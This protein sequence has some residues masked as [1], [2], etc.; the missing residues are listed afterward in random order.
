[1]RKTIAIIIAVMLFLGISEPIHA[2]SKAELD[3]AINRSAA[4]ILE[5]VR[6]PQVSSVGGEW[7]VLGLAR[8]G[9]D[10]PEAYFENYIRNVERYLRENNGVLHDRR[11]T[12]YSR[13]ILALTAAGYDPRN[14]AGFDLTLPLGDFDRVV[15]QGINGPIWALLALDSFNYPIPEN[16][17]AV[18]QATREL[19][20]ADILRRQTP[21]GGWNL[22]AGRNGV[23]SEN[24][25]GD[26]GLTGMALQALAKYQH[27][28]EV[29][30]ATERALGF[31]SRVQ[32]SDGGFSGDFAGGSYD[33]ESAVQVIVALSE[34][35]IAADDSRFV[36][37]GNT[38]LDNILRSQNADGSFNRLGE[39]NVRGSFNLMSTEQSFYGL[40]AVQRLAEG[41]NSLYRMTDTVQRRGLQQE[42]ASGLPNRH[43]DVRAVQVT[44]PGRTFADIQGHLNEAAI[45]RLVE[46][47][48]I[49]GMSENSFAP[50]DTMTRAEFAT[51]VTRSLGLPQVEADIFADVSPSSWYAVTVA[52]AHYYGIV[53]GISETAFNPSGTITRQEAA[54]MVARAALLA[55]MNTERTETEIRNTLAQFGDYRT[56]ATW[57]QG[58]LAFGYSEG[59]LSDAEFYI[60][61]REY[62]SRGEIAQMLYVLLDRANL[63]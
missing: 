39:Q 47:G 13:V 42:E 41:R 30:T 15:W 9:V 62:V 33:V 32:G 34:L 60:K 49:A 14:V 53:N 36:K 61:P 27:I 25:R 40:I 37:A 44:F 35:G 55:G 23:V 56:V 58:A 3:D 50:N 18:T 4:F 29:R 20:V 5:T 2:V 45:E 21:D 51:I 10:V 54:V 16:E 19:F 17:N 12:D 11:L 7:A 48:I 43:D 52:S 38:V 46:R 22:T 63:I 6:N 26:P 28:S 31:L 1:M 59:I 57:A 24:E 8:S